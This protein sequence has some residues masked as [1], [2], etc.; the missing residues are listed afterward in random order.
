[1]EYT[2]DWLKQK[3]ARLVDK[4]NPD[5]FEYARTL[6]E[7]ASLPTL[8]AYEGGR[9][10][11]WHLAK[12]VDL[13]FH[14]AHIEIE[15]DFEP[16]ERLSGEAMARIATELGLKQ[17]FEL[18]RTHWAIKEADLADVLGRHDL[19]PVA[20]GRAP[21]AQERFGRRIVLA[22]TRLL[23]HAGHS[24]LDDMLA[25]IGIDDL[26]AGRDLGGRQ[27]RATAIANYAL[28]NP[29]AEVAEGGPLSELLVRRAISMFGDEAARQSPLVEK[30]WNE[31]TAALGDEGF[32]PLGDTI[33]DHN[34]VRALKGIVQDKR[35]PERRGGGNPAGAAQAPVLETKPLMDNRKVFVIHG[36]DGAMKETVARYLERIGLE[37][38]ILHEQPN[39]GRTLFTKFLEV[40]GETTFAVALL[41]PDDLGNVASDAR[42]GKLNPRARQ[43]VILEMGFFIGKLG[44]H[45]VVALV[46]GSVE[47]PS[48][49]EGVVYV[50]YGDGLAWRTDL[51]R[52]LAAAKVPFDP[53]KVF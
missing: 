47:K 1:M 24:D 36:R 14:R 15:V 11:D 21:A 30:P 38:I 35:P 27:A 46:N 31:L 17:S 39:V 25:E 12:I 13:T 10:N 29:R 19:L 42:I 50:A 51:A 26:K 8:L 45:R 20:T 44:P 23:Q 33:L 16:T 49:F 28:R 37:P 52:E 5:M 48:D 53:G 22:A 43:N 34:V 41:H 32:S 3:F 6:K 4:T 7:L 18:N 2:E 9:E 40:A